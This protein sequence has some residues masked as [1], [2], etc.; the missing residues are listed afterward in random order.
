MRYLSFRP[1]GGRLDGYGAKRIPPPGRHTRS[2]P[3]PHP[4]PL[5]TQGP[6]SPVLAKI[7]AR[8]RIQAVITAYDTELVGAKP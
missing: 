7:G 3:E 2:A 4:V 1:A 6:D 5:L 8:D